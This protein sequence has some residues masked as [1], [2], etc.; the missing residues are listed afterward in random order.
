ML[1][2]LKYKPPVDIAEGFRQGLL[3]GHKAVV[4]PVLEWLLKRMPDLKKRA[5]LAKFLVKVEV[6]ND[7]LAD[8]EVAELYE[9]VRHKLQVSMFPEFKILNSNFEFIRHYSICFTK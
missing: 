7:F 3:E 9:Q 6:R 5:Y 2:V 1:R 4:Y 8:P